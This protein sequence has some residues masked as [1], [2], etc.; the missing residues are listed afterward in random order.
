MGTQTSA[1]RGEVFRVVR[2][3]TFKPSQYALAPRFSRLED[4]FIEMG[5]GIVLGEEGRV[6][7]FHEKHLWFIE[8]SPG[9]LLPR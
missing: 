1:E 8:R 4:A 2:S 6:V 3:P 5:E 9:R 7:A